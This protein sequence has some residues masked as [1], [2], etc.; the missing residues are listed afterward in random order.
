MVDAVKMS[1]TLKKC[2][3]KTMTLVVSKLPPLAMGVIFAVRVL[4]LRVP[5]HLVATVHNLNHSSL[6]FALVAS[7]FGFVHKQVEK[8]VDK[9]ARERKRKGV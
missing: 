4:D 1:G 5:S 6:P 3:N 9:Q 8:Q 2:V 7:V